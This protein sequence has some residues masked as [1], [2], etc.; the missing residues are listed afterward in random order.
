M[1]MGG[2]SKRLV[3]L[4]LAACLALGLA[5]CGGSDSS[6]SSTAAS[7]ATAGQRATRTTTVD[8]STG[9]ASDDHGGS[10]SSD[11][12]SSSS[13]GGDGSA[14]FRTSGGDNSIQDFGDEAGSAEVEAATTALSGYLD[15]RAGGDWSKACTY[16]ATSAVAPLE[17]LASSSSQLKGKG[18]GTILA[19][20]EGRVPAS[21]RANTLTGPISSL[22]AEGERGFALYHGPD[23]VDYFVPMVKEDDSWKV[24]ALAPSEFP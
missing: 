6:P 3:A 15:A 21:S 18:C 8:P 13:G 24:G 17:R 22:R 4:A 19:A 12:S 1:V 11:E 2:M 7:T 10:G 14:P 16:L 20:L 23:G 9:K 5:A